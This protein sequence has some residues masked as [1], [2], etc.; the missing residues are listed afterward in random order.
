MKIL[1][2]TTGLPPVRRGG[3]STYS[4]DLSVYLAQEHRVTVVYPGRMPFYQTNKIKFIPKKDDRYPF[5]V[6]EIWNPLPVSLG[7]GIAKAAPYYE[8]RDMHP[9]MEFLKSINPDV[10]HLHTIIGLPIEFLKAA[11]NLGIKL[12]Y[13]THDYFGLCP[14]MLQ[15]NTAEE[16]RKKTCS[17][18]CMLCKNG[19]SLTKIRIMQTNLYSWL[20]DTKV[21]KSL[22]RTQK[23]KINVEVGDSALLQEDEA[24]DR[25]KQR[26]YYLNVFRL[27]DQFHFNS[28]VSKKYFEQF[29]P[30]IVG[31]VINITHGGLTDNRSISHEAICDNIRIGFV[32][33]YDSRKGFYLFTKVIKELR[34]D[35]TNFS[36]RFYGDVTENQVFKETWVENEGVVSS[37]EMKDAYQKM[38]LLVLPS[39]WKETFGFVVLEA[40]ANGV[41]CLVSE[42]VGAKDLLPNQ[43]IFADE[44]ELM[45]KITDILKEPQDRLGD[46]RDNVLRL[47]LPLSFD[48]HARQIVKQFYR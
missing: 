9:I 12:I 18:E 13:T 29:F 21:L 3:L 20:K 24:T 40:L 48:D 25:Y 33:T 46:M 47:R 41:P 38:D 30:E 42:N 27:I 31:K 8:R 34:K 36:V 5:E 23:N 22:R 39:L 32:G 16:L 14:K 45:Q 19:P 26:I 37:A 17:Y 43:W 4:T 10:I 1:Q 6:F 44:K 15:S 7:Y 28:S 2:Y 35:F 11:K